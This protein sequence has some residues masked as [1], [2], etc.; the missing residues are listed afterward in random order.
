M[1]K[2]G[3]MKK[4]FILLGWVSVVILAT[5]FGQKEQQNS[6]AQSQM[7]MRKV[8]DGDLAYV[9]TVQAFS[10]ALQKT[11]TAGGIVRLSDC[12]ENTVVQKWQPLGATLQDVLDGIAKTDPQYRWDIEDGVVNVLPAGD[13]PVLLKTHISTFIVK[14]QASPDTAL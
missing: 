9:T 3:I 2:E 14:R 10:M 13:E 8:A 11:N 4:G 6:M 7:L 1:Q 5:G 12:Q